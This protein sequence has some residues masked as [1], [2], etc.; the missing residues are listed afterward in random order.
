M[1]YCHPLCISVQKRTL[2]ECVCTYLHLMYQ[3]LQERMQKDEQVTEDKNQE[4]FLKDKEQVRVFKCEVCVWVC[5]CACKLFSRTKYRRVC[6]YL[7]TPRLIIRFFLRAN[8]LKHYGNIKEISRGL[9]IMQAL[10]SNVLRC[11]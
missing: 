2:K 1:Y 3:A 6:T 9:Y 5:V 10:I 8:R 4:T 11:T 7:I